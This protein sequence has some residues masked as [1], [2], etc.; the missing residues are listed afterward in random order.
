MM[1]PFGSSRIVTEARSWRGTDS[2][3]SRSRSCSL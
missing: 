1:R 2:G 3:T